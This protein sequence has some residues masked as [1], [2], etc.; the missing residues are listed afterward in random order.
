MSSTSKLVYLSLLITFA[1]VI[2]TIESLLVIPIPVPGAK[3]GLANIIT[4]LALMLYG[5]KSGMLVSVMRSTIGFLIVGNVVSFSLSISGAVFSTAVMGLAFVC[6]RKK[7]INILT[8]SILGAVSHNVAQIVMASF[9]VNQFHLI[10]VYLPV[11][12]L[13]AIPTGVFTGLSAMYLHKIIVKN[14]TI[15]H[16]ISE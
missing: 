16:S 12:L 5:F 14:I 2:H 6:Y 13:L 9:V 8:V 15:S 11:L 7:W 1:V 4:L 10:T 3:L